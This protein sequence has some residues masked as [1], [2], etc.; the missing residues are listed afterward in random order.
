[1]ITSSGSPDPGGVVPVATQLQGEP[2]RM[3]A[4]LRRDHGSPARNALPAQQT[5]S[6]AHFAP[7][8]RPSP[9]RSRWQRRYRCSVI[10][11]DVVAVVGSASLYRLWGTARGASLL[12]AAAAVVLV[13]ACALRVARAWDPAVLGQGSLEYTRLLRGVVGAVVVVG[14]TGLALELPQSRPFAFGVLPVAGALAVVG[15]MALRKRLHRQRGEGKAMARVL[16]V[17]TEEAVA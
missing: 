8:I 10:T 5:S 9:E 15:R 17:G 16:V 2:H 12:V 1:M 6:P 7:P 13:A 4:E 11:V 14:L 3:T